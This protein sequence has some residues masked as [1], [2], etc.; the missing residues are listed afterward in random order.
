MFLVFHTQIHSLPWIYDF[1]ISPRCSCID[2]GLSAVEGLTPSSI[3]KAWFGDAWAASELFR[4]C[5]SSSLFSSHRV[6]VC[7][8]HSHS[9]VRIQW[10]FP[11]TLCCVMSPQMHMETGV[12][13]QLSSVKPDTKQFYKIENHVTL[14]THVVFALENTVVFHKNVLFML[15]WSCY[16]VIFNELNNI[17]QNVVQMT[18]F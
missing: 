14:F 9:P 15:T 13:I 12:T 16:I 1:L 8:L 7:L 6:V 5:T 17:L 3:F 10:H 18:P 2:S 4:G 11:E